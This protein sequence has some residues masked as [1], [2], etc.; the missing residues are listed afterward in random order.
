[1]REQRSG[2]R[3]SEDS[4]EQEDSVQLGSPKVLECGVRW[5]SFHE[6]R[7]GSMGLGGDPRSHLK[8]K[9]PPTDTGGE[10]SVPGPALPT[11]T[12]QLLTA[13]QA[14]SRV[15]AE[16]HRASCKMASIMNLVA[17]L[18]GS[19]ILTL[20]E[21]KTCRREERW[22]K[23]DPAWQKPHSL[24]SLNLKP[25]SSRKPPGTCLWPLAVS[26]LWGHH[27]AVLSRGDA[28]PAPAREWFQLF[29]P[30]QPL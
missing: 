15:T 24:P 21:F 11:Q 4:R 28:T 13:P 20:D 9:R 27:T 30:G 8:S 1:M 5:D 10:R 19:W 14:V 16:G 6:T 25:A 7:A 22:G 3:V 23:Q 29:L 18:R 17:K 26:L 2:G 12:Q